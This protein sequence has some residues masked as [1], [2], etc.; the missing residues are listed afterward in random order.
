MSVFIATP[1]YSQSVCVEYTISLVQ[2]LHLLSQSEIGFCLSILPGDCFV[3]NARNRL[4]TEFLESSCTDIFFL[5]DDISWN[6]ESFMKVLKAPFEITAGI[7][8][9]KMDS[10]PIR[11]PVELSCDEEKN[12]ITQEYKNLKFYKAN[13][14]PSGFMRVRRRVFEYMADKFKDE[15]Y[16]WPEVDGSTRHHI[17][18]FESGICRS[19][20][21]FHGEDYNF[22]QKA[23][24][25][26]YDLWTLPDLNFNHIG[27]KKYQGNLQ[28]MINKIMYGEKNVNKT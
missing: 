14:L 15:W 1:S 18:Y 12:L 23:R 28:S 25:S 26:G 22:S 17:P 6:P 9:Q 16:A 8:P 24:S 19:E 11:F 3:G 27:K 2:T 7:Y 4:V 20:H 13:S 10:D 21:D 5:D